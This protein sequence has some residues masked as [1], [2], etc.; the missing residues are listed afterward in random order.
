MIDEIL[1]KLFEDEQKAPVALEAIKK[2]TRNLNFNMESSPLTGALLRSLAAAKPGG[3]MLELGTGTGMG[4]S[5]ILDGMDAKAT[6]LSV[7][8]DGAVMDIARKHLGSDNRV[9]FLLDD[10]CEFLDRL[11]GEKFDFVFADTWPGKFECL[12]DALNLVAPNGIYVV[13]DLLPQPNW[14][15][16]HAPKVK[17]FMQDLQSRDDFENTYLEWSTGILV[18][19]KLTLVP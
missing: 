12:T 4:T 10:G 5:W 13:D 9:E 19:L 1:S 16:G 2:D 7:D 11:R 17:Q 8:N 15:E 18:A 14:P 6:L 3:R